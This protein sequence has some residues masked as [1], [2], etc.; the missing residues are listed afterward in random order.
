MNYPSLFS[1]LK[2]GP[3]QLKHRPVLAPL[4]RMRAEKRSNPCGHQ[5]SMD[6]FAPRNDGT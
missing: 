5:E 1:P 2:I 6:C 4:T 3:Y